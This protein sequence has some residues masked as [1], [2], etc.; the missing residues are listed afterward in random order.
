MSNVICI[1]RNITEE[2]IVSAIK[3]GATTLEAVKEE[4]GATAGG[5]RGGRCSRKIADL[6]EANK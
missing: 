5:C 4:T 1:C 2:T 3:N 6:I